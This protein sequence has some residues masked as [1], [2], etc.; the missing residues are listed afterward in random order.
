MSKPIP[1]E[2][3]NR[4]PLSK[5][6]RWA[7][8]EEDPLL[9]HVESHEQRQIVPSERVVRE[10]TLEREAV[11]HQVFDERRN[12]YIKGFRVFYKVISVACCAALIAILLVISRK[13]ARRDVNA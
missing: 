8:G 6:I 12:R 13:T 7:K 5:V 2:E 11:I 10:H 4:K 9:G 3:Y 1:E